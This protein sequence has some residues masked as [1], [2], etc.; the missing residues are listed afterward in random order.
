M[1]TDYA[2]N[3]VKRRAL[4][5]YV[6]TLFGNRG[7][8][9]QHVVALSTREAEYIGITKG[10][11]EAIWLKGFVNEIGSSQECISAMCENQSAIHLCKNSTYHERTRHIDTR[12]YWIRDIHRERQGEDRQGT[13][14]P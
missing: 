8:W 12:L 10:V 1:D 11:K 5:G 6:F 3:K 14:S 2:E 4:T 9:L 13:Y 7:S